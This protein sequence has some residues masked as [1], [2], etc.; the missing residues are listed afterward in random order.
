MTVEELQAQ[1][2]E[3]R[4]EKE[5]VNAKNRE[6]LTK[7]AKS[8]SP[9]VD[10]E[11]HFQMVEEFE[12]LKV[13]HAKL[14]KTYKMESEKFN[15]TL[16]AKDATLQK[17]LIEDN[18]TNSLAKSG[19]KPEYLE[20]AKALLRQN[21]QLKDN[22]P[23]IGDKPLGDAVTEWIGNEGKHFIS[24]PNTQG[25]GAGGSNS[26]GG[27]DAKKY[28]DKN[29]AEFSLTKQAEIMQSNPELYN[30]LKG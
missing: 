20:A 5:A 11:K 23:F 17:H 15:A 27:V 2:D 8:K 13:E 7:L 4:A 28:F 12:N 18:L 30:Q 9:E 16:S 1:L 10:V 26:T 24:A 22:M 19:V 21:A 6:L 14:V 25:G 3:M 29:N